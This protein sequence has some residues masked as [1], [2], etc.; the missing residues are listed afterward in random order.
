M[1]PC[2]HLGLPCRH[3]RWLGLLWRRFLFPMWGRDLLLFYPEAAAICSDGR[4]SPHGGALT[5]SASR[6]CPRCP[7]CAEAPGTA[8][9]AVWRWRRCVSSKM[10]GMRVTCVASWVITL[11]SILSVAYDGEALT[12]WVRQWMHSS[13]KLPYYVVMVCESAGETQYSSLFGG[14]V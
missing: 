7:R 12:F 2:S 14:I 4:V 13:W 5:S 9:L 11:F 1:P 6:Q 10:L 8:R 3:C